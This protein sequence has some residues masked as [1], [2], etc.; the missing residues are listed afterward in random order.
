MVLTLSSMLGLFLLIGVPIAISLG[1]ASA[2]SLTIFTD[3]PLTTLVQKTF[4]GINSYTLMA[5]P[6]FIL[7]SNLF[8]TGGVARRFINLA[9]AFVG[10]W[11]GGLALA[12]IL[13]SG[14]FAA[15][16]GSSSA[17]VIAI[18]G[19][20]IPAMIK[21]GYPKR[22]AVGT[23]ATAGTLGIMIPPSIPLIVYG[24][25]TE[26]PIGKLFMAGIIPGI[27]LMVLL[28]GTTGFFAWRRGLGVLAPAPWSVKLKAL[29]EASWSLSIPVIIIGGI[30]GGFFTPTEAAAV[31]VV[32]SFIIGMFIHKELTMKDI[33]K[34]IIRSVATTSML[35]FIIAMAMGFGFLLTMQQIPQKLAT[36]ITSFAVEPWMILLMINV[37]LFF[38][39][40][41]M[42]PSS[43]ILITAPIFFPIITALGINPIHFGII[44]VMNM[45][46]GMVTP[47]VGLNLY[48]AS[49]I[50]DMKL[51]EVIKAT[52]PWMVVIVFALIL[53]TYI[54]EISLFVPNLLQR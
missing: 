29:R 50:A 6:Y 51:Y 45:E 54:P 28:M 53:V 35:F 31:I 14:L 36:W 49:E 20:M 12:G 30:Y 38:A 39:G 18:G 26:V 44:M 13:A 48:V 46:M 4:G 47:P 43:V 40:D 33:P 15:I 11:P 2:I 1:A 32:L 41:F 5:G 52:I 10:N 16:S 22:F 17:T 23:I 25:A 8:A 9:N 27:L 24:V 3:L 42:E 21:H 19:I 37:L 34:I 7:A